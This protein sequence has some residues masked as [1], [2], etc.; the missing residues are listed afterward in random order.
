MKRSRVNVKL[1]RHARLDEALRV[2]DILVHKKIECADRNVS[3]RQIGQIGGTR[4]GRIGRYVG[5]AAVAA[6]VGFPA[7]AVAFANAVGGSSLRRR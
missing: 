3:G 1:S 4:G 5:S 6:Q 2:L 7:E